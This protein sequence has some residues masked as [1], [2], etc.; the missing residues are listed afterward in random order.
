MNKKSILHKKERG[1]WRKALSLLCI[2][3][4]CSLTVM[5]QKKPVSGKVTDSSGET[6]IGA[7]VV[8]KGTTNGI[9]TDENGNFTLQVGPNAVIVVSY[10]GYSTQ[11]ITV[12]SQTSF[13]IV[14]KEDN[15]ALDEVVVIGYGTAKKRDLTGAISTVKT[16]KLIAE[17]PKTVQD[18]LRANSAG[19][20]TT[21]GSNAKGNASM[22]IRGNNSL[23]AG[24][25]P[26]LVLDGVIYEGAL[27][28]VNPADIESIDILKDASSSAVYGA[29]SAN[30][31]IVINTKK[32][33]SGKPVINF[34]ANVGFV[35]TADLEDVFNGKEFL[36][37]RTDYEE[38]RRTESYLAEH[39]EMFRDP[40]SLSRV[41]QLDWYNYDQ[42]SPVSSV[43]EQQL[44]T[45]YLTRL[46]LKAPEIENFLNGIETHWPDAVLQR[47][48]QQDYT[49]SISGRTDNV[50]YYWSG[51]YAD[52]EGIV[53]GD[54]FKVFRT[55]LNLESKITNFLS[56]GI[57][58]NFSQRDES[59]MPCSWGSMVLLTPYTKSELNNPDAEPFLQKYPSYETQSP[60]PFFDNLYRDRKKLYNTL[61]SNIYARITLPFGFEFQSNFIPRYEWYEYYNHDSSKHF[62][63]ATKGGEST[64]F[65]SKT[66]SWQND[67]ILRWK[68]DFNQIHNFEVT[69]L[70][71]AEKYQYW[72]QQITNKGYSPSD[73]LGYHRVQAGTIPLNESNDEVQTGDALMAR[74]FYSF[75]NKYLLTASVRRD[76]YSAFGQLYPRA[77][78]PS[79][80]LGWVFSSEKFAESLRDW[81]SYGKLRFSWGANGNRDI[82]RYVAL[83]DM[84]SGA[85]P[86]IDQNGN[87]YVTS[88]L[89]VNRMSNKGL[90]WESTAAYNLGLDFSL[91]GDKLSGSIEGYL[92]RTR[93]LLVERSLPEITGFSSVWANLGS[94]ANKGLEITLNATPVSNNDITWNTSFIFSLNRRKIVHLYGDMVDVVD[95][96][97][98][99]I[100]QKEADDV[101][102]QWFIG[103]DPDQIW[104]Y[105]RNG[106]WQVEE[107]EEASKYGCQPGDFKYVDQNND[108]VLTN[109]DKV[110]QGYFTPRFRWT[111]RNEVTFLKN[112]S[113]SAMMY[114]Y[115]GHYDSF[116]LAANARSF[117]DRRSEYKIPH[118]T[119]ENRLEDYARIGSKNLGTIYN[120]RSF[121]R[122]EN[123]TLSYNVPKNLLKPF[124]IQNLRISASVHNAAVFSP[125]WD[126]WDPERGWSYSDN[127]AS[128]ESTPT[129]RTY[130]LSLNFTL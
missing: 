50:S 58:T 38:G 95:A 17:A 107:T 72:S 27:E 7:N 118:W 23:K 128:S 6:V 5:A 45:A 98:N 35:E 108:G 116:N 29:K 47:G 33:Q 85:H 26:L 74:L 55:R 19:L 115:W 37:F 104:N 84:V 1:A 90:K 44:L 60:D 31:V 92:S 8:E 11:E 76:G 3:S 69:L 122:L 18:L 10:I 32:G 71:N 54:A 63:W 93:D 46:E 124:A 28:D 70:A 53:V 81:L 42:S 25:S 48:L 56:V 117:P 100:G 88:Q 14:L 21:M 41:S 12:G 109:E 77:T 99:V 89:Y 2:L 73:V 101:G 127:A 80:A 39:P 20:Y 114:S 13:N 91:F 64:R 102:N 52:R 36:D 66:Y 30:G 106:V 129:P 16:D 86:Y 130:N 79:L 94:V 9:S 113:V 65:T 61:N 22:Q 62:E 87:V 105:V 110:F 49:A 83:S 68:K 82:G 34:N 96:N 126:W 43:T 4:M 51:G 24:S 57:N 119:P 67:N 123:V 111:W 75:S 112:F 15:L 40:R 121:I 103:H 97:G 125:H 120:E 59:A 78:F